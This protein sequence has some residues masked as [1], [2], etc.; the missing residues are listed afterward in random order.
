MVDKFVMDIRNYAASVSGCK[1]PASIMMFGVSQLFF[2]SFPLV[3]FPRNV[4]VS[5]SSN[6]LN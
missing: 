1:S 5:K 6:W 2:N 3:F 4:L